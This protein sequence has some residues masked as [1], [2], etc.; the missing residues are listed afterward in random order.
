MN[1]DILQAQQRPTT[2]P[3]GDIVMRVIQRELNRSKTARQR[4]ERRR[5]AAERVRNFDRVAV[6]AVSRS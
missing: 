4:S 3:I 1:R 5:A 2:L 6:A